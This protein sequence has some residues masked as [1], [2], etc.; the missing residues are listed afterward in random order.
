MLLGSDMIASET[1]FAEL[2]AGQNIG[3]RCPVA[4]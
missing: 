3:L 1:W 2:K 4:A